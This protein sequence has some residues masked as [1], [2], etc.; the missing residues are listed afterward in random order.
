MRGYGEV[1]KG[2]TP[3]VGGAESCS[4]LGHLPANASQSLLQ[5]Q[6]P[7]VSATA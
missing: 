5:Q 3:W 4:E 7:S 2:L 1:V 6:S